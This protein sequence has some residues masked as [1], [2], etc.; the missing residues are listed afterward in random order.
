[1]GAV[2]WD[3]LIK[4]ECR[5]TNVELRM[6]NY[7]R[8]YL[9]IL[10]NIHTSIFIIPCSIFIIQLA[11]LGT[12]MVAFCSMSVFCIAPSALFAKI[13]SVRLAVSG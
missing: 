5:I 11:L 4:K 2:L 13:Q 9:I 7:E 12:E 3:I 6:S 10:K 1:M 8:R